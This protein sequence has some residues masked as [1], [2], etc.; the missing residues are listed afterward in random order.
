MLAAKT[1]TVSLLMLFASTFGTASVELN[2]K[3]CQPTLGVTKVEF[4][5]MLPTRERKWSAVVSVDASRCAANSSGYFEI[6]FSRL[7]EN[8]P[9][10]DITEEFIWLSPSVTVGVDFWADEAVEH[11]WINKITPCRCAG[12]N[13]GDPAYLQQ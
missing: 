1:S 6:G 2:N 8:A 13:T 12:N 7:K 11:Y 9:D 3:T 5:N 10:A 4:S